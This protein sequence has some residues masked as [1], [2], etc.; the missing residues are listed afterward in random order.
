M[1]TDTAII[2]V[3]NVA[4]TA[5]AGGPYNV[6]E[7]GSVALSGSGTDPAGA[8]DPL[9]YDW[10]LDDDDIF[11]SSG[12]T[13][14]FY[15]TTLDGPTTVT[16]TL[17]VSDG[18]G[19]V[20]TDTAIITVDNVPPSVDIGDQSADEGSTV[21][22]SA[23]VTDPG[24]ADTFIY[25]WDFGDGITSTL[26]APGHA[27]ADNGVYTVTIT[28]Y[29]DDGGGPAEDQAI[30]SVSNVTPTVNAGND[31]DVSE[32]TSVAFSGSFDDP[33]TVDTH[34]IEW[35]FGDGNV[36]TGTLSPS[37]EYTDNGTYVVTLTVRDD[38]GAEDSDTLTVNVSNVPPMVLV[39]GDQLANEGDV[40]EFNGSFSDPGTADTHEI[41]WDFGDGAV[42]TETLA[43]SHVYTSHV[44]TAAGL[45]SVTLTVRDDDGGE[46]DDTLTVNVA[47]VPPTAIISG[48]PT[49]TA[50]L[51]ATFDASGSTEPGQNI[52]AYEWD[53]D[54]DGQY[55]DGSGVTAT[56]NL[57]VTGVYTVGLRVT[58]AESTTGIEQVTISI[59]PASLEHFVVSVPPNGTAGV[60][61]TTIITAEDGYDNVITGWSEDVTL[62]TTNGGII[63]P[64]A[65]LGN[66]FVNGVWIRSVS[67]TAADDLTTP[68]DDRDVIASYG[69]HTGQDTLHIE[70]AAATQFAFSTIGQQTAGVRSASFLLTARDPYGNRDTN[71]DGSHTLGWSGLMN[72]PDGTTPEYPSGSAYF[73]DGEDYILGFIAYDA[74]TNVRLTASESGGPSGTSNAFT[75]I[76]APAS[77]FIFSTIGTQTA[78]SPGVIGTLTAEDDFGNRATSYTGPHDLT[79]GGLGDSPN[80]DPADYPA[81]PVSFGSGVA[82]SLV[83][84]PYLAET[85]AILTASEGS[86]SGD[87]NS[88]DVNVGSVVGE[89]VIESAANGAGSQVTTHDM[90]IYE[91][92]TVYA[93]G[94]D[95]WGNY[96]ADQPADWSGTGVAEDRVSPTDDSTSTTLTPVISGTGTIVAE[97]PGPITDATGLITVRAPVLEV[98]LSDGPDPVE[99]GATLVYTIT[100]NNTGNAAATS[101]R[102]TLNL[103]DNVSYV[104][105]SSPPSSG[106]GQVRRWSLGSMS[107]GVSR[108]VIVTTTVLM[109]LDNGVPLTSVVGLDSYQT[110]A[111]TDSE[112]TTVHS[113]PVL[114]I[115]KGDAPDPVQAGNSIFYT[116]V[117]SNT[118]NMNATG[119]VITDALPAHTTFL[120]AS[121]GGS[122]ANGV[123]TWALDTLEVGSRSQCTL[124]V[125]VDKP[126]AVGTVITNTGYQIDSDQTAPVTGPDVTTNV[127][128]PTLRL[129]QTGSPNPVEAGALVTFTIFYSN[130]GSGVASSV[131]ITDVLP[132]QVNNAW[133]SDGGTVTDGVVTWPVIPNLEA[134]HGGRRTVVARV[135]SPLISG[136]LLI[137]Q[138][139]IDSSESDPDSVLASVEVHSEPVLRIAKT[140]VPDPVQA[141][142]QLVYTISYTN[143]GNADAT[144]VVI[145]DALP[146][147]TTLVGASDGGMHDDGVV[148]WDLGFLAGEGGTG[149]VIVTVT[150]ASPLVNGTVLVNAASITCVEGSQDQVSEQTTVASSPQLVIGI[151]DN[152]DPVQAGEQLVYTISYANMGNADATGVV[153]TDVLP[154]QTTFVGASDGGTYG[155]GVVT[156]NLGF[157][158]GEGGVGSVTLTVEVVSPLANG[159][160]LGNTAYIASVEGSHGQGAGQTTVASSPQLAIGV[161][162]SPDPVQAGGQLVYTISYTN[163]GNANATGVVVTDVLPAQTTFVGA[164][165]GGTYG[166]GVVTW[167]LDFLA[168]EGGVGSVTLT[169]DV[170][171]PLTNGTTLGNTAY[172]ASVEG[173]H[174]QGAGQTTVASSPQLAIGVADSPDPV[175]AGGQLV[176]T[177]S[178]ANTGNADATGVVVTHALPAQTTFVGASDGGTYGGG[179]ITWNV[180]LLGGEGG[181]G[182]VTLTVEVVSPLANGTTLENTAYIASAEGSHGQS[183][184]QTM[185]ASSPQLALDVTDTPDPVK[186]DRTLVYTVFYSNTGNAD[187]TAVQLTADYD[188]RL[189]FVAAD[190]GPIGGS[191]NAWNLPLLPGE[192]GTGMVVVTL[193]TGSLAP[194][195]VLH[196]TLRLRSAETGWVSHEEATEAEAVDL[197]LSV[198]YD[199]NTP[200]PGKWITYTLH[201][202]NAGDIP[203]EGVVLTATLPEGTRHID[204]GQGWNDVGGGYY[205][206]HTLGMVD[207][208]ASGSIQFV[209][210]VLTTADGRLPS[211]LTSLESTFVIAD[212][213][214]NGPELDT[215]NNQAVGSVGLPDLV[216][217]EMWV[218]PVFPT[219][220]RPVTFTVVLH[221]QG[222]GS[223]ENPNVPGG[224]GFWV[225]LFIDPDSA[226]QSYP[227][228]LDGDF[229]AFTVALAPGE[230]R[231]IVFELP[232]GLK[233][234]DHQVYAKVDNFRDPGLEPWQQNS[235]VPESDE[236]NNV[237]LISVAMGAP[238]E[239]YIFLPVVLNNH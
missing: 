146:A 62:T 93:A 145:T 227:W 94:Y 129:D 168:G 158:A 169:M 100:Y 111:V 110:V 228:D 56:V 138:A 43:P 191:D 84:T 120:G 48:P 170:V 239:Y 107:A 114:H 159:T 126:L 199:D 141:G 17:R 60:G 173:S 217:D 180:G 221:N 95:A 188:T 197:C 178:Y 33:G 235:L 143:T 222:T 190:P 81:S 67:L 19:G 59:V 237:A 223:A 171:S 230:T 236:E 238:P 193:T 194:D 198:S 123:V 8:N 211:G 152:P 7:G 12:Q 147:Q 30:V 10:D 218:T 124:I 229:L 28:V 113:Q 122:H 212:N 64:L 140:G 156:W 192:G 206:T 22:F 21:S 208:G 23:T 116:L 117:F 58:D 167:N 127:H 157:L 202:T 47:D 154:A 112:R 135:T 69:G 78:G 57:T 215:S 139:L 131:R 32:G 27:Y 216:I 83:F 160:T 26:P 4:P 150:V 232:D 82:S 224:G 201:Y 80:G 74:D 119:V 79:W 195:A 13:P 50:G 205:Y 86:V 97:Y 102:L 18:D 34:E 96:I 161:A 14:T 128:S 5:E 36:V 46:G 219:P 25:L 176:Y 151:A 115:G 31:K 213:G 20:T 24:T 85:D 164:S 3:D 88:F 133:A 186:G 71:Y 9:T 203:A 165:D 37:H 54:D 234:Q 101:A 11:E 200:Y 226:P 39:G 118:G 41:E 184:G 144:G 87:S 183:A 104:T 109:P 175:Q 75:V 52:T 155:G 77:A 177:I 210:Q 162:D 92:W 153:I 142:E 55:D 225:D 121:C 103:D 148:T 40:V 181:V 35:D 72:S 172:I 209:V 61:F 73:F 29:D 68:D 90:V 163:T 70:P 98:T 45:F 189:T 6:N 214:Q 99:A 66:D 15:A 166:G 53:L 2:T 106:S 187:A 233:D 207:S 204:A 125:D 130:T 89:I 1:T 179:V 174:G 63:S 91:N 105:A 185:V 137:N 65:A 76:H 149:S 182:S 44:Y 51:D 196:S 134:H 108:Q 136:T 220:G 16:V 231:E 38:D 132:S 42:V 49:Q